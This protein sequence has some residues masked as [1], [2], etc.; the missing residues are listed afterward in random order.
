MDDLLHQASRE[1]ELLTREMQ[2]GVGEGGSTIVADARAAQERAEQRL[3]ELEAELEKA[4]SNGKAHI[5]DNALAKKVEELEAEKTKLQAQLA[6]AEAKVKSLEDELEKAREQSPA[7]HDASG[8]L[9]AA[10]EAHKKSQVQLAEVQ[11]QLEQAHKEVQH[12]KE[13]AS[14]VSEAELHALHAPIEHVSEPATSAPDYSEVAHV[15][16]IAHK[17]AED[18]RFKAHH[19]AEA[20]LA[21]ARER[22]THETKEMR[23]ALH[24]GHQG[25]EE[26]RNQLEID[27]KAQ[28][29]AHAEH[30][31]LLS[32]ER[33]KHKQQLESQKNEAAEQAKSIVSQARQ[34]AEEIRNH[35]LAETQQI[36]DEANRLSKEA[37]ETLHKA[38]EEA[39][40]IMREAKEEADKQTKD[41]ERRVNDLKWQH[42]KLQLEKKKMAAQL[43][44][45]LNESLESIEGEEKS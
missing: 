37:E 18:M 38:K 21:E 39:E 14:K 20:I 31:A 40:R 24:Q 30:Q 9:V 1:I 17:A 3:K 16:E 7:Q 25:L 23:D 33:E 27:K 6:E 5:D 34:E 44:E 13:Q 45:L 11:A 12:L 19:D 28:E 10:Q 42:E 2:D 8:D 43:R 15:L 29:S 41:L 4:R 32:G 26:A 22:A 36:R 35:T